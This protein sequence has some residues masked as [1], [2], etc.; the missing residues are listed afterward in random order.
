[1][2]I[3]DYRPEDFESVKAIHEASEIDYKMP[4]LNSPLFLVKKVLEVDGVVRAAYGLRIQVEAYL[5]LA[6]GDWAK[7]REKMDYVKEL[8]TVSTL[9]AWMEGV[10]DCVVYVPPGMERFGKRIEEELGFSKP[11]SGWQ[12]FS[13]ATGR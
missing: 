12:A 7:P 4:D 6:K 5:W 8:D 9:A 11:R 1:M 2:S 3:R 13:K 10:D